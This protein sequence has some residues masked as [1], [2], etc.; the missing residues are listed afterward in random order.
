MQAVCCADMEHCCPQGYTCDI[1]SSSCQKVIMLQ[2]ETIPLTPI[3]LPEYPLQLA[4]LQRRVIQ[5]DGEYSCNDKET[6]CRT[7]ASTWG[8][9]P[10]PN[11]RHSAHP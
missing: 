9:C 2:L 10:S 6:C 7:S 8:C 4:P 11:V 5:C 3:Y 1:V